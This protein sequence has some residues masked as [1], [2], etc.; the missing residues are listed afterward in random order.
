M[1]VRWWTFFSVPC[2]LRSAKR[3]SVG[4][5][6]WELEIHRD[7]IKMWT[8]ESFQHTGDMWNCRIKS[9]SHGLTVFPEKKRWSR[10]EVWR[11]LAPRHSV[12]EQLIEITQE[13]SQT[14]GIL[15]TWDT[16]RVKRRK[17]SR[18][19]KGQLCSVMLRVKGSKVWAWNM[20]DDI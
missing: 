2:L 13:D 15:G 11:T 6:E 16:V 3:F 17:Y 8:S 10:K 5:W 14:E 20:W 12:E 4:S 1:E 19:R 9:T 7:I 18:R